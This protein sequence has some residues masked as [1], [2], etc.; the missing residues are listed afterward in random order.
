[1]AYNAVIER[2]AQDA[3]TRQVIAQL[4]RDAAGRWKGH[5]ISFQPGEIITDVFWN[6][7][8]RFWFAIH[9][10]PDHHGLLFGTQV[11][12]KG[13]VLHITVVIA[14]PRV[15]R[16][17]RG[18][19]LLRDDAGATYLAHTGRVGGGKVGI[20]RSNF[21]AFHGLDRRDVVEY[22]ADGD[23]AIL[24]GRVDDSR[25]VDRIS[26]FV[27]EVAR[28]K[29]GADP[30]LRIVTPVKTGRPFRP[31][32]IG[33]ISYSTKGQI[34]AECRH[35]LVASA[36]K[37]RLGEQDCRYDARRDLIISA[38]DGSVEALYEIKTDCSTTSI[39]TGVGQ[40][41]LHGM[42]EPKV[43]RL[44]LVIP[45]APDIRTQKA[46][47]RLNIQTLHFQWKNSQPVFR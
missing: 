38:E 24:L 30:V 2:A 26:A 40:L 29:S 34:L 21:V 18:G 35:D 37:K 12:A 32:F 36:L 22:G 13:K 25:L 23:Y 10:Q 47:E 9:P 5:K 33:T 20:S 14:T 1:M 8:E 16:H 46:L 7:R 17:T 27:R 42:A 41:L 3:A 44:I 39:Y 6:E 31:K 11:P 15:P 28:F 43:P 19:L 45:G 4:K